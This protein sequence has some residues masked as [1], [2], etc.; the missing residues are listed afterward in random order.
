MQPLA[1]VVPSAVRR[2][3]RHGEMS[4]GKLE[5]AWKTAVGPAIDRATS[6]L[7]TSSATLEVTASDPAWRRELKRSQAVILGR[8]QELLGTDAVRAIKV[9]ARA[10]GRR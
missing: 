4:Q 8:L 7:L 5:F 1:A 2:L 6:I 9:V 10:G 3:L